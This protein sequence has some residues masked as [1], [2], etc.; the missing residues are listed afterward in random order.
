M[1][2]TEFDEP[3]F[4][5]RLRQ[6]EDQA[7]RSLIRRFHFSLVGVAASIIGSRARVSEVLNRRRYISIAMI[8]RIRAKLGI[9]ADTLIGRQRAA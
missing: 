1:R 9:S 6:G 3:E 4:L 7:Y 2:Q 8:A 5:A